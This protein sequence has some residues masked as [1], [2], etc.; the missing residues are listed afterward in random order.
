PAVRRAPHGSRSRR[1][2]ADEA[3][4]RGARPAGGGGSVELAP[5]APGRGDLHPRAHHATGAQGGARNDRG[6]PV[7]APGPARAEPR[8]HFLEPHRDMIGAALYLTRRSLVNA[9]RRRV[10]RLRQPKYLIGFVVGCLYLSW[11][12]FGPRRG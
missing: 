1:H 11:L 10:A 9:T 2:P 4:H 6:D 5:V 7:R 3:H 8:R 12:I